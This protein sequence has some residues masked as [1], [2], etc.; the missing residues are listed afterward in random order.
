MATEIAP[1]RTAVAVGRVEGIF[2][3]PA[4]GAPM[5]ARER[6]QVVAGR[7]LEGD[8]YFDGRGYYSQVRR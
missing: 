4:A 5:V 6:A 7:G 3:A 2:I 8:R 1:M